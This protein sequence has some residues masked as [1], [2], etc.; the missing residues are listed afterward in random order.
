MPSAL[1]HPRTFPISGDDGG[2]TPQHAA[3]PGAYSVLWKKCDYFVHPLIT[4][5]LFNRFLK[6]LVGCTE[7]YARRK[8]TSFLVSHL[9]TGSD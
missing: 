7:N 8:K 4:P 5:L 3:L 2:K 9:L 6:S 1:P